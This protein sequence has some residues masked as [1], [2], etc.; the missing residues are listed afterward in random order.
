MLLRI[1]GAAAQALLEHL[2]AGRCDEDELGLRDL[3][4]HLEGTLDVDLQEDGVTLLHV[5]PDG[6][7]RGAVVVAVHQGVLDEAVLGD[8]LL[9]LLP[10]EEEVLNAVLLAATRGAGG[11][12]DRDPGA[13]QLLDGAAEQRALAGPRGAGDDE[14]RTRHGAS[15]PGARAARRAGACRGP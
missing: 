13:G 3:V 6:P 2:H 14:E 1:R 9:E 10:A 7:Q 12:A 5:L 8:A 11:G 15:G 4:E